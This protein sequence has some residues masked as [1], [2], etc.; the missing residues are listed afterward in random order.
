MSF[1][2]EPG[3]GEIFIELFQW[4]RRKLCWSLWQLELFKRYLHNKRNIEELEDSE[5]L[6]DSEEEYEELEEEKPTRINF[7]GSEVEIKEGD[8]RII[9]WSE[10]IQK[11][12]SSMPKLNQFHREEEIEDAL[13]DIMCE[14]PD[15]ITEYIQPLDFGKSEYY[16]INFRNGIK[17]VK[18]LECI[19]KYIVVLEIS[20][21]SNK[22]YHKMDVPLNDWCANTMIKHGIKHLKIELINTKFEPCNDY[23]QGPS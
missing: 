11:I 23:I 12:T 7:M 21:L 1:K 13:C 16:G 3:L 14:N 18:I 6:K 22:Y 9:S 2:G 10:A 17:P 8:Y 15:V 4:S 19:D 5:E 20:L